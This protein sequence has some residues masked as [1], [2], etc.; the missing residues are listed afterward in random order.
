M[1][2]APLSPSFHH[3]NPFSNT[4]FLPVML[5][6]CSPSMHRC[7]W[8]GTWVKPWQCHWEAPE[9]AVPSRAVPRAA[10]P[11]E[12]SSVCLF[13]VQQKLYFLVGCAVALLLCCPEQQQSWEER[14]SL[15]SLVGSLGCRWCKLQS[16]GIS[17]AWFG[18]K[19]SC[20]D[21]RTVFGTG[22]FD[23]VENGW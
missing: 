16:K 20:F 4:C 12:A 7:R 15:I 22:G 2:N 3:Q 10:F 18:V 5:N 17:A 14:G 8:D 19:V 6:L 11:L 9:L 13:C 1:W 21:T 23:R